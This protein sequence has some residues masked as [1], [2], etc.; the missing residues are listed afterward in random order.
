MS[1]EDSKSMLT[2]ALSTEGQSTIFSKIL[3]STIPS[4]EVYSDDLC[5]A[6]EDINPA[7][8][9]HFLVI[10]RKL[11][12]R[13]SKAEEDDKAL[14]GHLMYTAGRLGRERCPE[15]FRL[16]VNDGVEG[17]QSVY[18]LHVHVIGGRQM[19]WPPG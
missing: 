4:T 3:D 16:V 18:H 8:P 5:Y 17:A 6:F 1:S 14:L 13:V 9:V 7:G 12:T 15:G 19:T 11:I 2:Q 10:P